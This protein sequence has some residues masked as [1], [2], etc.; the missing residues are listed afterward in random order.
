M[1]WFGKHYYLEGMKKK[2][3]TTV[4]CLSEESIKYRSAL[5]KNSEILSK[6]DENRRKIEANLLDFPVF[7]ESLSFGIKPYPGSK[8]LSSE[9][10]GSK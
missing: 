10:C 5:I 3:Y 4:N 2:P 9:I 8:A 6:E 7:S 1:T